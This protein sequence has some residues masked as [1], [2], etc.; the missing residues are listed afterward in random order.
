MQKNHK[1][2]RLWRKKRIWIPLTLLALLIGFR[3]ALPYLVKKYVN[4]VLADIPGYYGY[5]EDI[6]IALI[7]GAY[8]IDNL[9]L[10]K[11]NAG[12]QIP[13]LHFE[14]TD[15]SLE[16]RALLKGSVVSEIYMTRPKFTYV[17]EDQQRETAQSAEAEDWSKALTDLVPIDINHLRIE[18][19]KAAF[20]QLSAEPNIDLYLNDI[21]LSATNLRNVVRQGQELPSTISATATSIGQGKVN[22]EGRLNLVKKIPDMDLSFSLE[23]ASAPAFNTFTQHYAKLDFEE[24]NFSIFSEMA[25]AEGYLTGYIKPLLKDASL[26]GKEDGFLAT[27]WEGFVGFFKFL[28]KNKGNNTLATKVPLQ[29]NLN[30]VEGEVW[31]TLFNLVKNGWIKAFTPDTDDTIRFEDAL[32]K[33]KAH[34]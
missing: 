28:L 1:P 31:P 5:V 18:Q 19:G 9:Y 32:K 7:R 30:Q 33:G 26:I 34:P 3:L 24:G 16:W 21:Q 2:S 22:L 14:K 25:I 8:V 12:S 13:F 10:N 6:D 27:L 20:V 29:G 17:F 23:N 15:I 11:V 4:N